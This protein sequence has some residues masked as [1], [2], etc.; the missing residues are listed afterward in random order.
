[1]A[2]HFVED[3]RLNHFDVLIPH[4][5]YDGGRAP[6]IADFYISLFDYVVA[7]KCD[8]RVRVIDSIIRVILG[9][10]PRSTAVGLSPLTA[11][12]IASDGEIQPEDGL[13]SMGDGS[14]HT[15]LNVLTHEINA[16]RAHPL[17]TEIFQSA[18]KRPAACEGCRHYY[19]CSGGQIDT[20]WSSA[21]RF[22][23][24][25]V[26]C[27]DYIKIFDHATDIVKSSIYVEESQECA[28]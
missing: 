2:R 7:S 16:V 6:S 13:R 4:H 10:P 18:I 28:S 15:G 11:V 5:T 23:N 22:A 9:L 21:N 8:L 1:M 24:K 25:S 27:E 12:T 3:L 19:S 26:Y 17:W 14:M 20:R